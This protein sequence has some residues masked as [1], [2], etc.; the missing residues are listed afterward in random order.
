MRNETRQLYNRYIE[1]IA[2]LNSVDAS[3]VQHN[4]V[5][6]PSVQQTL[7][8]RVQESSDFLSRINISPVP[9]LKGEKLGLGINSTIAS[10]TD[11]TNAERVPFD[12]TDLDSNDYECKQTNFDTAL[13]YAKLDMWA[14]FPDFETRFRDAII[15]AQAL[16]R[17]RIGFNGVTA[18]ANTNRVANP[19][20]QDVNIGWL[21]HIRTDKPEHVFDEVPD[22]KAAGKVTYGTAGDYA[23]LDALVYDAANSILP[24]WAVGDTE[25]VAIIGRDLVHDKYFPIVQA[26]GDK[27]TEQVARDVVL[28]SKRIGGL[29]PAQVPFMPPKSILITRFDNLSIYFQD[30]KRRRSLIDNPKRDRVENF[31]S[32]NEAYVIEDYDFALLI[33]NVERLDA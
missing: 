27:A 6:A 25:L 12:P 30:G 18:A 32:S 16:D 9:E 33:D 28:S 13:R 7:E 24:S 11:T 29:A 23:N 10:R 8:T 20:L 21:T 14:K 3:D 31:E 5:V 22:G 19:L 4:F 26:A 15:R 2:E 1:T 17:I